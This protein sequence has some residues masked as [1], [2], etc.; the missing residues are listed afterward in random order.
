MSAIAL[1]KEP[2]FCLFAPDRN[3]TIPR[4]AHYARAAALFLVL[5]FAALPGRTGVQ[6]PSRVALEELT[7]SNPAQCL[8]LFQRIGN[9]PQGSNWLIGK[10]ITLYGRPAESTA[11]MTLP[12][13]FERVTCF[14]QFPDDPAGDPDRVFVATE[15]FSACGWI[16]HDLL[17]PENQIGQRTSDHLTI[18]ETPRAMLLTDYCKFLERELAPGSRRL[19]PG[20]VPGGLRSKGVL[21]GET[22]EGHVDTSSRYPFFTLPEGGEERAARS[23]FAVL[24][25]HDIQLRSD[26]MPMLLVGDGLGDIF[27]WI[28]HDGVRL[29]PTRLGLFFDPDGSGGLYSD[30]FQMLRDWRDKSFSPNI[31]LDPDRIRQHVHGDKELVS[32]PIVR[33]IITGEQPEY[34]DDDTDLDFHEVIII[35]TASTDGEVSASALLDATTEAA[36]LEALR[37]INV[38]ILMDTTESMRDYLPVLHSG[39]TEFVASYDAT[40]QD[41]AN[42]LPDARIAVTAYSDFTVKGKFDFGDPIRSERLLPPILVSGST[43]LDLFFAGLTGHRGL[44]DKVGG[45][46][47]AAIEMVAESADEFSDNGWFKGRPNFIIHIADHGSRDSVDVKIPGV[48]AGLIER[49]TFYIPINAL[50]DDRGEQRRIDA[51]RNFLRQARTFVSAQ[52]LLVEDTDDPVFRI[53]LTDARAA[54]TVGLTLR[55]VVTEVVQALQTNRQ[56]RSGFTL[57]GTS[58]GDDA[59]DRASAVFRIDERLLERFGLGEIQ[60]ELQIAIVES[61]FAPLSR[62]DRGLMQEIAWTYTVALE[63]EQVNLLQESFLDICTLLGRGEQPERFS[64]LIIEMAKAFSGDTVKTNKEIMG[65]LSELSGLPGVKGSFLARPVN[66]LLEDAASDDPGVVNELRRDVCWTAYHFNNIVKDRY[67]EPRQL[68]WDGA[69]YKLRPGEKIRRRDYYYEPSVG[70]AYYYVP[71]WFFVVPSAVEDM[72]TEQKEKGQGCVGFFCE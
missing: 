38:L 9:R 24:E 60:D 26:D 58:T 39:V 54:D 25:I 21:T 30:E 28:S 47:E 16:E 49:G 15:G 53:D 42:L 6:T 33:T 71:S 3:F 35:G 65:I 59:L 50:T 66:S 29:W 56:N 62:H 69:S 13:A 61:G 40:R 1:P 44:T 12:R 18:C 22:R 4:L 45:R 20:D 19:C 34:L 52:G 55:L 5:L 31:T 36:Q 32:Y 27:G 68:V 51:R 48:A 7:I 11:M 41:P 17:L 8:S 70:A 72:S 23:F 63:H 57:E 64:R 37:E 46:V 10:D 2:N 67:A 43:N 14:G